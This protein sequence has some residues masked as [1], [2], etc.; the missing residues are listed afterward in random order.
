MTIN[1][2]YDVICIGG[3]HAG[4]EAALAASRMG[5]KTLLISQNLDTIGQLSCNPAIGG[6]GK[7]HIVKE[8]D[9]LGGTM[10][11]AADVAAIHVRTLNSRKGPAVQA[12]RSQACRTLYKNFIQ[13]EIQRAKNL[14][15]L[16]Q[17]VCDLIVQN[18]TVLGVETHLGLK[19]Y[20]K[21]VILTTGTFLGGKLFIGNKVLDGGRIAEKPSHLL[22]QRLRALPLQIGRL[23]TGTPARI[24]RRSLDFSLFEKQ[25][26][27]S[28]RP[29][30]S[31][32]NNQNMHPEQVLCYITKTTEKTFDIINKNLSLSA[33]NSGNIEGVGPRYCPSI[34]DKIM[35][36]TDKKTHQV[37]LE[38]EGLGSNE[39]Y[40]NGL[41][42]SL[43]IEIQHQFMQSV[44]G[45]KNVVITRYAYAVE[46]DYLDPRDLKPTLESQI[47]K[48]LYCAGQ[49]NGT[50]GYEE[51]AGQG[52]VA[53]ANAHLNQQGKEFVLS[54]Y[55]SYIGV[56]IDDLTTQGTIEPYRMFTS[57]AE[58]RIALRE[59]N[60]DQRLTKKAYHVGLVDAE[61]I[62]ALEKK[63]VYIDN[64]EKELSSIP[65]SSEKVQSLIKDCELKGEKSKTALDLLCLTQLPFD[66]FEQWM[67]TCS[68]YDPTKREALKALYAQKLY[69]GYLPR[70]K[71]EIKRLEKYSLLKI[72]QDFD[73]NIVKGLSHELTS[74]LKKLKPLNIAQAS[75]IQGMTPAGLHLLLAYL[76]KKTKGP[77]VCE[78]AD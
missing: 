68:F 7:G 23:K 74:K 33:L 14:S 41:S 26:S 51:A 65:I 8:I 48:N 11:K 10:G 63:I 22:A 71:D 43:P 55:E 35:K 18:N 46:Y 27:D 45:F 34:E 57:R 59:D 24:D 32:T 77:K 21:S 70:I 38:P 73:Y 56:M 4:V 6:I 75:R 49:I 17:E 44:V 47:L 12:T 40:P 15:L 13:K 36:F 76:Q 39:I 42:T 67:N 1:L 52:I 58:Y 19:I 31:F 60:A 54:R 62:K 64:L 37:F 61:R 3:G 50:T 72:S 5:S 53:G 2:T 20:S 28:P 78:T 30:F 66:K 25:P 69:A 29:V 9:A 16:Q